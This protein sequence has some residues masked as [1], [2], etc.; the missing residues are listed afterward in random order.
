MNEKTIIAS[1]A[2]QELSNGDVVNL[3]IGLP[4]MVANYLPENVNVI[5]QSE[6]GII[7]MRGLEENEAPD[8]NIVNAGG[9]PTQVT[10]GAWFFDSCTSF[11][12][13][14]GGHVNVTMLGALQVDQQ[15]NLASHVI[16][17]KMMTGMGGAMDLVV[18]SRKVVVVMTHTAKGGA[19]KILDKITLP[20]TAVSSVDRI[21]T[22]M[23]VF[24]I[25][26][27]R[28]VLV[29]YN[30]EFTIEQIKE[31]TGAELV[32]ADDL[33]EMKYQA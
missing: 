16:P 22:E 19:H 25:V 2:A 32:I 33:K 3:G 4:T 31:A 18:G 27:N 30:K 5:L 24:D 7:G 26:N 10:P 6:N 29:E 12:I 20:A 1:R 17:G 15:G 13:I 9:Q 23:G 14:R 8:K 21:I 28:V 11:G